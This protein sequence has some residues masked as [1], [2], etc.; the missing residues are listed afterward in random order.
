MPGYREEPG[1]A[2]N[3]RTETYTAIKLEIDNWRWQGVPFFL[4]TGKR[5]KKVTEI[6]VKFRKPA[7][8]RCSPR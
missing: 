7:R 4:R 5:M 6:V 8:C 3:S 1:V 2:L